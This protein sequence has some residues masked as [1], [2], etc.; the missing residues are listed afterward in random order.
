MRQQCVYIYIYIYCMHLHMHAYLAVYQKG[1]KL[2]ITRIGTGTCS[3]NLAN[4]EVLETGSIINRTLLLAIYIVVSL[5]LYKC[6][7]CK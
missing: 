6:T 5:S 1:V 4:Y 7:Y 2:A 3:I